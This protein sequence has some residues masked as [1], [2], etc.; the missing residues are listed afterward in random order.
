M[1]WLSISG[2]YRGRSQIGA[3]ILAIAQDGTGPVV[4][5]RTGLRVSQMGLGTAPLAS[6]RWNNDAP[7]AVATAQRAIAAGLTYFDTAPLYG[8]GESETRL[9]MALRGR[10]VVV[11]TKVGRLLDTAA[12]GS[13]E[14]HFDFSY[15]AALRSLEG[16]LRRLHLDRVD[17]VHI[18]DPDEHIEDA[19]TGTLPALIRM[20]EEEVISGVSLGTNTVATAAAFLDRAD[21]DCLM[22]AGRYTLL[23]QSAAPL[24]ARCGRQGISYLAAGVFNSGVLAR[25]VAGA[26]LDYS[27][28]PAEI[29]QR[30]KSIEVV[31]HRHGTSLIAA[32]LAFPV[33]NPGV[34]MIVVGMASP[35]E[36]D[37][38]VRAF[39]AGVPADLW[40]E[41]ADEGLVESLQ[42]GV[43]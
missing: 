31:C 41:L 39:R 5:G 30:V 6:I 14:V 36:V 19:L 32:A 40:D 20:R 37:D 26:W 25:P 42:G 9:G 29:L 3:L 12:D 10:S 15:D 2:T 35:N 23:D 7:T 34:R 17:I 13:A 18:H 27:P 33:A 21:L 4:L 16:S 22:V 43:R 24:I 38:N 11:A 28:V 1:R 8:M